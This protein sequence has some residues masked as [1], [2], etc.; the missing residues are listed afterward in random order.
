MKNLKAWVG[1]VLYLVGFI[2]VIACAIAA[3][4]FAWRNPDMT[5]MRRFLEYP[6]PTVWCIVDA[7]AMEVG[8]RL[9]KN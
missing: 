9:V 8:R 2:G 6:E 1:I 5:G 7:I 3:T 4:V